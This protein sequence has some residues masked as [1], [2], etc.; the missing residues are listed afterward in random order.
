MISY[1]QQNWLENLGIITSLICIWLN[2][3]QNV[4]GWFWA[5]VSSAIYGVIFYQA[6]LFSDMGLQGVFIL[7][8]IYGWFSW[9]FGSKEETVLSV[10]KIPTKLSIICLGF[11]L[12]FALISGYLFSQY[13]KASLPYLDSSLTAISLIATWMTARKYLENW[14]LWIGANIIY[15]GMYFYKGL[16]G[17]AVLYILLI[18]LAV[19]GYQ[20]WVKTVKGER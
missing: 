2:T 20:D 7:L 13:T 17:T 11:F 5:I 18:G 16:N 19:K 4:W 12:I 15:V 6:R 8:S 3:Q 1:L 14:L 10:S 9:K